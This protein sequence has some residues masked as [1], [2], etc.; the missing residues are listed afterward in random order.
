VVPAA[1]QMQTELLGKIQVLLLGLQLQLQAADT[2]GHLQTQGEPVVLVAVVVA[3]MV[4]HL[5]QVG[6]ELLEKVIVAVAQTVQLL[7][8]V[9][10]LAAALVL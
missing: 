7:I 9:A 5:R 2:V 6:L 3:Q 1:L 10:V 4:E 8:M